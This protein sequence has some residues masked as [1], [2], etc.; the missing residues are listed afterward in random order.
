MRSMNNI[1]VMA[2]CL[3]GATAMA[4]SAPGLVG[5]RIRYKGFDQYGDPID[6]TVVRLSCARGAA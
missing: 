5:E 1:L 4:R 3:D 6:R 2:A